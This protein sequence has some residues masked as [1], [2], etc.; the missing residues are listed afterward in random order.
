MHERPRLKWQRLMHYLTEPMQKT[1]PWPRASRDVVQRNLSIRRALASSE[2]FARASVEHIAQ[3]AWSTAKPSRS[4]PDATCPAAPM[5]HYEF[6][7]HSTPYQ[8]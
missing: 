1:H 4:P 6:G 8:S 7:V 2:K 5:Q 3:A